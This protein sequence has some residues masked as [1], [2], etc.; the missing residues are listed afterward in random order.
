MALPLFPTSVVGSLPRPAFVLDLIN[1]RPPLPPEEYERRMQAAVRY[2]VA[3]QEQAGLDVL[4]DGEW[5]RKSYIGVIAELAHGFELGALPDGRP[6][7]L[8][9]DKLSPKSPGFIARE[10]TFLKTIS[11]R[12]IKSTLPSPALLG[13][14]MWSTEKSGKAYPKREDF[15]RACVPILRREL[16]LVRDAGADIAQIDDPHLCLFV[17]P[18]VR[19]Q[20]SDPDAAA[21]FAVDMLN[22]VVSGIS[23][24][25]I[26]V[27]LCRRAG[28][29]ARGEHAHEGGYG[30]IIPHLNRLKAHHL[31]ME[32]TAPQAGDMAVFRELRQD[33]EIGLGCVDVTPG[34]IDSP[35]TI[36][37]RVR[38][39]L[40]HLA[41]ERITLNPDCGFAP[42]SGAVV[43]MDEAYLKLC[44]QS[45][46]ARILR[47]EHE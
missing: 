6:F 14:R 43:S 47:A 2:A 18:A 7:T 11:K 24:I 32:F 28:A 29:R 35:G 44:N 9:I 26:A 38:K 22:D 46:A 3:M 4:T 37:G 41:A 31:T 34:R 20:Y 30:P 33:F 25:K 23:G 36:A 8:V 21:S 19:S 15:V 12:L 16:E 39:A 45:E 5:W 40:K 13:E 10:V 1:G 42:G 27:H 17:D